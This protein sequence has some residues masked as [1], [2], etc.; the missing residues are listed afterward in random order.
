MSRISDDDDDDQKMVAEDGGEDSEGKFEM[1][2][3]DLTKVETIDQ[4]G[5]RCY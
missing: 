4:D 2:D 5:H 3:L 1:S